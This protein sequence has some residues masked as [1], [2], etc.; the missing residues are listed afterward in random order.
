MAE[1]PKTEGDNKIIA[2]L[3]GEDLA[4]LA[5]YLKRVAL[6][7]E[8]TLHQI[9]GPVERIYFPETAL[10]SLLNILSDGA[11]VEVGVVGREGVVGISPLLEGERAGAQAIVQIPGT[12][13]S[14]ATVALK[15]EFKRGGQLQTLV[16]RYMRT[17]MAQVAQTA[18]CNCLHNVDQRLARWLLLARLRVERD[19]L[20]LTQE[21]IAHMLGSR[22]AGVSEAAGLLQ[23]AG[24]I[25]YSRGHIT[26]LDF[27]GLEEASCE[28]YQIVRKEFQSVFDEESADQ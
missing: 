16:L 13:Q 25:T 6:E 9:D 4:R 28:C 11:S 3:H 19:E 26:I 12:A 2:G 27:K 1:A 5:P 15:E 8:Q 20:P 22:R 14:I 24:L 10:V 7:A 18:V 23:E 17:L 21:F